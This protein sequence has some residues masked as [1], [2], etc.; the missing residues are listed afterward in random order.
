MTDNEDIVKQSARE[1]LESEQISTADIDRALAGPL[2][3]RFLLGE[4]DDIT[5]FDYPESLLCSE[6]HSKHAD[7]PRLRHTGGLRKH[8]CFR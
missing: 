7:L 1:A 5:K 2:K 8:R 4:F 3:A 6:E